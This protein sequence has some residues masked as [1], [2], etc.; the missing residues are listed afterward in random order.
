MSITLIALEETVL[1]PSTAMMKLALVRTG[2][3]K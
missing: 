3:G 1:K 2:T